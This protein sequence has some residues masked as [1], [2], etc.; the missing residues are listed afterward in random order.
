[1]KMA[2]PVG[3][4]APDFDLPGVDGRNHS[5]GNFADKRA[6]V[7]V[8]SCNHCPYVVA[9]EDRMVRLQADYADTGVQLVA[10]NPND[11]INYPADSFPAM[12]ARAAEKGF[13]FPYLRDE[14][15]DVARAYGASVT[16]EVFL[17]DPAGFVV[18]HGRIDD[19]VMAPA[20]VMRHD[21]R[22][23]LDELLAGQDITVP[24]TEPV[25]CTVKW[26]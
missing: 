7:V 3:A 13:N 16:P 24:D 12:Q 23:A 15:Q 4:K 18:Y 9:N 5:L 2:I 11:E 17:I 20:S 25:G 26:K 1:M 19:N 21:L 22:E 8:F 10:I 6:I 14:T